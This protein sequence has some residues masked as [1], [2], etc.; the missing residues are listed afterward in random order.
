[1]AAWSASSPKLCSTFRWYRYCYEKRRHLLL[2]VP[3]VR[4]SARFS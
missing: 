1:V 3:S 2:T 4:R